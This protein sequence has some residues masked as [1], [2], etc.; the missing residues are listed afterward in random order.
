MFHPFPPCLVPLELINVNHIK[1]FPR[2]LVESAKEE[3]SRAQRAVQ[4]LNKVSIH[5]PGSPWGSP[6]HSPMQRS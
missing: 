5:S 4:E 3:H 6:L 2:A 1:G